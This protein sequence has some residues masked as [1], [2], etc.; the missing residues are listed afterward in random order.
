LATSL[1][2]RALPVAASVRSR[3]PDRYL[4]LALLGGAWLVLW[5]VLPIVLMLVRFFV[6]GDFLRLP[7]LSSFEKTLYLRVYLNTFKMALGVTAECLVLGYIVAYMLYRAPRYL[8]GVLLSLVLIPFWIS[9]IVRTYAL[10]VVLGRNGIVNSTLVKLGAIDEPL[11]IMFTTQAVYIGMAQAL[12]PFMVLSIYSSLRGIDPDLP[13]AA[14]ALGAGALQVFLRIIF[15]L[16]MPGVWGGC[17]L[18]FILALGYFITPALLGG[19]RDVMIAQ[20]IHQLAVL[21]GNFAGA[22]LLSIPLLVATLVIVAV[23]NRYFG[24]DRIWGGRA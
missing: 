22:V 12:L 23:F 15:P 9:V 11:R 14:R 18:V 5:Y 19:P 13:L 20:L 6:E 3:V 2:E 10:L 1:S 4:M 21:D 7:G 8:L 17:T 16:S 24:L